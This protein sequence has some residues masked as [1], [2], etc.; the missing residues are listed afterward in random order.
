MTQ[1]VVISLDIENCSSYRIN[2]HV[3]ITM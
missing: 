3:L 2:F 1:K